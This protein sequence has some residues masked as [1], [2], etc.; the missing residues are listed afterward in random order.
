M[1]VRY[2][3]GF[4]VAVFLATAGAASAETAVGFTPE[5]TFQAKEVFFVEPIVYFDTTG[6]AR[7]ARVALKLT[8]E[9]VGMHAGETDP[10]FYIGE[11][12]ANRS[13][14]SPDGSLVTAYFFSPGRIRNRTKVRIETYSEESVTLKQRF[15]LAQ[16]AWL[17]PA[18]RARHGLPD[19]HTRV[20]GR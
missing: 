18:V 17:T 11:F 12:A 13:D 5:V 1:N 19:L 14:I 15:E 16:V 4:L 2:P 3:L 9:G 20:V 8:L 10:R 7:G 6:K